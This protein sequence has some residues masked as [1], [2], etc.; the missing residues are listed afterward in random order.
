MIPEQLQADLYNGNMEGKYEKLIRGDFEND[1]D[2]DKEGM[3]WNYVILDEGHIIK[4]MV[5]KESA[6]R[7]LGCKA[8]Q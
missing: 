6:L 4:N 3:L 5:F 8:T 2:E 1:A 7:C